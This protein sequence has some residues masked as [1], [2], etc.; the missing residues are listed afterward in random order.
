MERYVRRYKIAVAVVRKFI[1][2]FMNRHK[3]K[4]DE[5][6][7]VSDGTVTMATICNSTVTIATTCDSTVT[8]A[9]TCDRI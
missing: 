3:P 5:N 6:I 9:T 8:V 1:I 7:Y 2:G 4:S